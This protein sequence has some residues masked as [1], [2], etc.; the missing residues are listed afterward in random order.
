MRQA[1]TYLLLAVAML[2]AAE[3]PAPPP[4]MVHIPGGLYKPVYAKKAKQRRAEPFFMDTTQITNAQFLAFVAKNPTWRRSQ[5]KS[6]LADKNY[7]AHW[8][9][10]LDPGDEKTLAAP[11]V[12]VSWFAAKAYCESLGRRLPTQDEWEFV[13]RADATRLDASS[14]QAFLRQL[15]EWYSRPASGPLPAAADGVLNAHGVRGQHGVIWEWV[16][17]FNSTMVVGDS[18]GDGSLERKLFCGAGSLLAADVSNYAAFMRYAFR[19][20]LKG[21]YCVRSLGFRG[22]KSVKEAPPAP[23]AAAFTTIYD[24]PGTWRTQDDKPL[25]LDQLRGRPRVVTMGF[26]LCKFACPRIIGDMKRIEAALGADAEKA[27]FVFFS[28]DTAADNPAQMKKAAA[29]QQLDLGR[30]T[31]AI[32]DDETIRQLAVTL[33]FKFATVEGFLTHSN[34]IAVLDADGKVVH[35]EESLGADIAPSIAALKKLLQP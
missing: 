31:F 3:V 32:S 35:R 23:A 22:A 7:L 21:D 26:T 33:Q 6:T 14:D 10:D 1:L 15:L 16:H 2:P 9:G 8:R 27:G 29:E 25:T 5:V 19:S 18:R 13:A 12:N 30:W 24:L 34:L 28:F 20:S 17:D 4:G 11:V